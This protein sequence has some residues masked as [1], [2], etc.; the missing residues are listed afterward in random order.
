MINIVANGFIM[1]ALIIPD[2]KRRRRNDRKNKK[3][4]NHLLFKSLGNIQ[5]ENI[6]FVALAV[7]YK[8]RA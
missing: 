1:E 5:K 3:I 7:D 8:T 4:T 2:E 6:T